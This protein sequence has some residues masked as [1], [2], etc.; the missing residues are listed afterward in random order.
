MG[1]GW[2]L[3]NRKKLRTH[4]KFLALRIGKKWKKTQLIYQI[5]GRIE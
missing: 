5:S 3:E 2:A 1:V 4:W